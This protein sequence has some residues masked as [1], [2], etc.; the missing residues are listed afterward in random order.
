MLP[1]VNE[2]G[3]L[4]PGIHI[5]EWS[6]IDS[7]FGSTP[8]RR[9]LLVGLRQALLSLR[10]AGCKRAYLDGSFVTAKTA[11]GDFDGCWE[12]SGVQIDLVDPILLRFENRRLAQKVKYGGELFPASGIADRSSMRTYLEFFQVD[13]ETGAA[14]GIIAIDLERLTP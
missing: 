10:A 14:K 12:T 7:A 5:A 11:P 4:P 1:P 9:R 2:S 3:L 6:E 13:K 8:L